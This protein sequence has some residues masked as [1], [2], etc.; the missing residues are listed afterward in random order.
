M[1][2]PS[3]PAKG[4]L[5]VISA[6]S[7]AG[8]TS[9]VKALV[10]RNDNVEVAISHTTRARR[11]D[12]VDGVNYFFVDTRQFQRMKKGNEFIES[13]H[14]FNYYYATSKQEANRILLSGHHLVLEIDWQGAAQVRAQ[15]PDSSS[16]FILPPS[17]DSLRDRLER[18]AQDDDLTVQ[19][20]MEAAISETSHY[21][22]FDYLLVNDDFDLALK[23]MTDI[24]NGE[25]DYLR[26][27]QQKLQLGQLISDLLC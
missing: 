17:I 13:A 1:S 9:L 5:F 8:K 7:G 27:E 11:P 15:I 19:H 16:I 24:I 4:N 26:L 2:E 14:V 3:T 23:E 21:S 12:E 25:G 20:R 10:A 18:R 22:D 6:P